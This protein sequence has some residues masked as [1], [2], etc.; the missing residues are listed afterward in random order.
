VLDIRVASNLLELALDDAALLRSYAWRMQ[1]AGELD[2]AISVVVQPE[3]EGPS[4]QPQRRVE[5]VTET[6]RAKSRQS[7]D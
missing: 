7:D 6:G 1:Q 5:F 3:E 4:S 2:D